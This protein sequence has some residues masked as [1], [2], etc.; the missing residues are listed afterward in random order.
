MR[1]TAAADLAGAGRGSGRTIGRRGLL[2]GALALAATTAA[3]A[4]L[5]RTAGVAA[6]QMP[7]LPDAPGF[8]LKVD[9]AW[10]RTEKLTKE[11]L[12]TLAQQGKTGL[13]LEFRVSGALIG[14]A[15]NVWT[16]HTAARTGLGLVSAL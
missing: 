1:D 10:I 8:W 7:D 3:T 6:A 12:Q 5:G 11:P 14:M 15:K 4:A 16:W 9:D 2:G 13:Q